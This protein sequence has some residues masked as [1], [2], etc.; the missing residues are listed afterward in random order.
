[1]KL[2]DLALFAALL[3]LPSSVFGVNFPNAD[4]SYDI[5]SAAAWGDTA[6]P[7]TTTTILINEKNAT[8]TSRFVKSDVH[9][10]VDVCSFGSSIA[11]HS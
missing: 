6:Y 2:Y 1:M 7:D 10:V 8:Y 9:P 4:K 11:G 5:Y 3:A